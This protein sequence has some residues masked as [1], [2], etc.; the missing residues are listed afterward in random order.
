MGR[1]LF[2]KWAD[3]LEC[4]PQGGWRVSAG[5]ERRAAA[6]RRWR[7]R[8]IRAAV[9]GGFTWSGEGQE[10]M[11]VAPGLHRCRRTVAA[12]VQVWLCSLC[13]PVA[14]LTS[15]SRL[16]LSPGLSLSVSVHDE[17][18]LSYMCR[19]VRPAQDIQA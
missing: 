3:F 17:T 19:G 1:T 15:L 7:R 2:S 8:S 11:V 5:G 10:I 14:L 18:I 16:R 13:V 4:S 9:V 6:R 12:P